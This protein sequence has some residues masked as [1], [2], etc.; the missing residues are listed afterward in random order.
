MQLKHYN[1]V[2]LILVG[3]SCTDQ[4]D[5][6]Y[7]N[8]GKPNF[9]FVVTDDQSPFDFQI[10][11]PNSILETAHIDHLATEGM[12]F[13]SARN[14]GSWSGAVCIPSRYMIMSG[15]TLWHLP[16][17]KNAFI[18][19]D[20]PVDL[21]ENTIGAVFNQAGYLTMRTCKMGNSYEEANSKFSVVHDATKR[22]GNE[23][24][25]SAWHAQQVLNYLE[26]ID[27][28]SPSQRKP[29]FIYLGFSHP[30]DIRDGTPE[31]LSRYGATN[32]TTMSHLPPYDE[33]QPPLPVNYLPEHP[34]FHG[35]PNLRDEEAISGVWKNRDTLTIKNELGREYACSEN[36]DIQLGKVLDKLK[37]MGVYENTY[38]IYTSDHGVALG[39]HGL[40]GKQNLY[41]HSWRVPFII[42][43]PGIAAGQKVRGNIYLLDIFPTL[44]DLADIEI[45]STVEGL[46][47]KS[48]LEGK[49]EDL[50]DIMLG[51]Y[52]GGTKPGMRSV[53][54]GDW[55]LIKYDLMHGNIRK[56]QLF[57]I[58][59]NPYELLTEHQSPH[60]MQKN[61]AEDPVYASILG[62]MESLLKEQMQIY[63]DPYVLW[64]Q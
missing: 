36:I 9:L 45:P 55:K 14:M 64:D 10:Y 38:I 27:A 8:T 31:L 25:G 29:F 32:H 16:S 63:D 34:F 43:G 15:R 61:L 5:E 30:H 21:A 57:N 60:A 39:S 26:D 59:E 3:L 47:F 54:K 33:V 56:T 24:E 51:I 17:Y 62:E 1:L 18:N 6:P 58:R 41:E 2:I 35:H 40:M 11:N 12:I 23:E 48:V 46:S 13:E 4:S 37:K 53:I 42:K 22:G 19:D 44:C 28:I 50:R 7:D 20:S 49:T 52:S